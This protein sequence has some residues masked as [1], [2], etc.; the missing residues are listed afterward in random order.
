[1]GDEYIFFTFT[2]TINGNSRDTQST[3]SSSSLKNAFDI[4]QH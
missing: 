4:I 3:N 1:M 2:Y